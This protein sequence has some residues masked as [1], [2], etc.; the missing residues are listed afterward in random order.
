MKSS[1]SQLVVD[2]E[3]KDDPGRGVDGEGA[4]LEDEI[5]NNQ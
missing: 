2:E 5:C 1:P 3:G 4:L